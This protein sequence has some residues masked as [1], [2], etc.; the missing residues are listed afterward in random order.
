[1][2]RPLIATDVPGCRQVVDPGV[3]GFL[4]QARDPQSLAEAMNRFAD[5]P[6]GARSAMGAA[7]RRMVQDAFSEQ[8][9]VRAYLDVL[10]GL[11]AG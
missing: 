2:A 3:N 6:P 9:V 4:C 7:S 8:L 10:D 11:P 5:L 1:M